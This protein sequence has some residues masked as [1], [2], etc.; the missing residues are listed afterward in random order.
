MLLWGIA[1]VALLIGGCAALGYGFWGVDQDCHTW[2]N[3]HGYQ[4]EHFDWWAKTGGCVAKT[5]G[6]DEVVHSIDLGAKAKVW[7]W[8]FAIFA[9]GT[10]PAVGMVVLVVSRRPRV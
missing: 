5:P 7:V 10:L 6:G 4:L 3:S 8:Q 9:L 2:V 1:L